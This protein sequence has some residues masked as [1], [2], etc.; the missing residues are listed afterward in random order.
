MKKMTEWA[1][2]SKHIY[3]LKKQKTKQNIAVYMQHK[4]GY[5]LDSHYF[6]WYD[7]NVC[8]D[9]DSLYYATSKDIWYLSDIVIW[10][11]DVMQVCKTR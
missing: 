11:K 7:S 3:N 2:G 6:V 10:F 1:Y 4:F 8:L 5:G 9:I